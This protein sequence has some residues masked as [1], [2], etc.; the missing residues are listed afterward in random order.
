MTEKIEGAPYD[1][2]DFNAKAD[3]DLALKMAELLR[4]ECSERGMDTEQMVATA[5]LSLACTISVSA[6]DDDSV[7][8]I[9]HITAMFAHDA[10]H[11]MFNGEDVVEPTHAAPDTKQ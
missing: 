7:C 8:A 2:D 1:Y 6:G 10:A 5:A 3:A 11:E 4:V 9:S